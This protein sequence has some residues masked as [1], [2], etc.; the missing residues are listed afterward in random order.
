MN[1]CTAILKCYC[2]EILKCYCT[3]IWKFLRNLEILLGD[4][5][6]LKCY[7]TA[8]SWNFTA[9]QNIFERRLHTILQTTL[10]IA[11]KSPV[12]LQNTE[13]CDFTANSEEY[14]ATFV[15]IT[16]QISLKVT[17]QNS[18]FHCTIWILNYTF[19]VQLHVRITPGASQPD[20]SEERRAWSRQLLTTSWL[21]GA[22]NEPN[23]EKS[24][25]RFD[26]RRFECFSFFKSKL[27]RLNE[28]SSCSN[29]TQ[30]NKSV[31]PGPCRNEDTTCYCIMEN[32]SWNR[33]NN[34][35]VSVV[36]WSTF[37][38][39]MQTR[40]RDPGFNSASTIRFVTYYGAN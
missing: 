38:P 9:L 33:R 14:N 22:A 35:R 20:T 40:D 6:I 36:Y 13:N 39:A 15:W 23:F 18:S 28:V 24:E 4:T 10:V 30:N 2:K 34:N 11:P 16:S 3:L 12:C 7:C 5:A 29:I 1:C 27:W 26:A 8:I 17:A 32:C 31:L 21:F 25:R 37:S 19:C